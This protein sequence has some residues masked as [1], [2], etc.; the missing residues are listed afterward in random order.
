MALYVDGVLA[1]SDASVTSAETNNGYWRIG[2]NNAPYF[3]GQ[4]DD[5]R[6]YDNALS[7][8]EINLLYSDSTTITAV[9]NS[10]V[11]IVPENFALA[12]SPNP[13][14]PNVTISVSGWKAGAELKVIDVTGKVVADLTAS[15]SGGSRGMGLR[16]VSWNA[17]G[18]ASGVYIFMLRY[19]K[20]ELKRKAM[21]IR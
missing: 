12:A 11:A 8:S 19:G 17:S 4:L 15:I 9:Q 13:F 6:V 1:A 14:N 10:P 7:A 21:L 2:C 16:R 20:A 5:I 18:R 3:Q